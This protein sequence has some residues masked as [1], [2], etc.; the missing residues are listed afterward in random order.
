MAYSIS[1]GK[2][3]RP[4]CRW[5]NAI[6][7]IIKERALEALNWLMWVGALVN[8]TGVMKFWF[9]T[10]ARNFLTTY[11]VTTFLRRSLLRGAS[12]LG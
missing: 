1:V 8:T 10:S 6:T 4:T 5:E 11:R 7:I 2:P 3:E 12:K 9:L